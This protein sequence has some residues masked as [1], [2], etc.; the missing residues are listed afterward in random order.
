[1]YQPQN[2]DLLYHNIDIPI[3]TGI[4]FAGSFIGFIFFHTAFLIPRVKTA[5][6]EW[7]V[8]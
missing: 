7:Q 3:F 6:D 4:S 8:F 1:M 5:F 2:L